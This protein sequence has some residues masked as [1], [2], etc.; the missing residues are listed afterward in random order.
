MQ[1]TL[2]LHNQFLSIQTCRKKRGKSRPLANQRT[3]A[4]SGLDRPPPRLD[5]AEAPRRNQQLQVQRRHVTGLSHRHQVAPA[6]VQRQVR[7]A[8][9]AAAARA[10]GKL[11]AGAQPLQRLATATGCRRRGT[12]ACGEPGAGAVG[13]VGGA[14][15]RAAA[16]GAAQVDRKLVNLRLC[17]FQQLFVC[18]V[19]ACRLANT[20]KCA[21][22]TGS[23]CRLQ[24][25]QR[26]GK[27]T[28]AGS[29]MQTRDLAEP[30]VVCCM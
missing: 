27:A 12:A 24:T 21:L 23:R 29:C 22:L 14:G 28:G 9:A 8:A 26:S 20:W 4:D 2:V 25:S 5:A 10:A 16:G 6:R 17:V 3:W 18:C 15:C 11:A 19:H 30:L 7:N 13:A 1:Y